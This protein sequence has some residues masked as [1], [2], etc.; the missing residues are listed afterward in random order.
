MA[1]PPPIIDAATLQKKHE[2]EGAPD[3]FPSLDSAPS[4]APAA[5][6]NGRP[7]TTSVEAFPCLAPSA[8]TN[9]VKSVWGSPVAPRIKA[10]ASKQPLYSDSFT[11]SVVDLSTAG[12]DGKPTSL[13]EIMR[14]VVAHHKIKLEASTNQ[15]SRQTTFYL[16]SESLKELDKAKRELLA[17]LSPVVTLVVN[18]PA[19]L[20]PTI[21]GSKGAT[22]KLIRDQTGVKIDIPRKDT[23]QVTGQ[24][25]SASGIETPAI[26]G[27]EEEEEEPTIPITIIGPQSSALEA[28]ALINERIAAR[29]SRSTQH[30]RDIPSHVLSFI[31]PH[32]SR[33]QDAAEG[34]DVTLALNVGAREITVS[35]DREGVVRVVETIKSAVTYFTNEITSFKITLPKRQHR[36]LTGKGAEDILAKSKCAVVIANIEEPGDEITV[37]GKPAD[38]AAGM[39]AVMEKANSAYIHEFPL[40]GPIAVSRQLLTYMTYVGYADT[41]AAAHPGVSVY[42][43]TASTAEKASVLNV[44]LVGDKPA[45]DNAVSQ[46][47]QL[48]GK[49]IGATKDVPI[50]WLIHRVI[51]SN[52]NAKK[53][54]AF[55]DVQNV[56]V[57]FPPESAEQSNVLLVYDPTSPN[58]SPSPVEKAG[59]LEEVEQE[60]LKLVKDAADVKTVTIPV[61]KKW[62]EAVV[63]KNGTTLNAIIGEDKALSIKLGADAGDASTEDIILIRGTSAD[64]NRASKEIQKI[65]EDAKNDEIVSSHVVEFVID[66][67]YVGRIV[68]ARGSGV[69]KLRD[70]L[71]VS[72]DFQ[73]EAEDKDEKTSKKKK[74]VQLVKVKIV[75]RKENTEDAEKR[76]KGQADRLADETSEI[77]KIPHEYHSS[78]IGQGGKYVIRLEENYAVKITFPRDSAEN[79]EGR[80]RETLKSDEV[81]IKGGKKGVADA[82]SELL[83]AVE[84]EKESNNVVKFSV[85]TRS[86]A[87]ILGKS[88]ATINEIKDDTGAQIDIDKVSDDQT[89]IQVRGTKTAIAEAKAAILAISDQVVEET[90]VLISVES[91][92]HRT[93]IGAGGQ[94]LKDLI[95]RCG[96]PSDPKI[97][98]G[99]VRFPRQ[100]EL[101]DDVRLRGEPKLVAK[102]QAELEKTVAQLKD[103]IVL[104]VDVPASQH[105][106][107][108]GRG[109][110]H[111]ND[112]QAK[113]GAQIQFPGSRS[114]NGVGEAENMEALGEVEPANLVKVSG[115]REACEK[116]VE[117]LKSLI[118]PPL[119]I[120]KMT[121]P[122]KYHHAVAQQGNFFRSLHTYGVQVEQSKQAQGPAVPVRPPAT[123]DT[124]GASARI[125]DADEEAPAV[126]VQWQVVSNYQDAEEGESVWTFKARDQAGLDKA[127]KLAEDAIAHAEKMSH[128][129]FL[130]LPDRSLFPRIV[131]TKGANVAKLRAESGADITVSRED[132]TIVI[133][134]SEEAIH[135]AKDAIL[136]TTTAQRPSRGGPRDGPRDGPRGGPRRD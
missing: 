75:G 111:L 116:A 35:G 97:Q 94:G 54:K 100:G 38:L 65:V 44:D 135:V 80:T 22:L 30:V 124:N 79:G 126:E 130:T 77:V 40:P 64:V 132:N 57:F 122:L 1:T 56:L 52:K 82:K 43:P 4:A 39:T 107:L 25:G 133:V 61:E 118:K 112:L 89:N 104:A 51:N 29:R 70:T 92:F 95:L 123:E 2:L 105:R 117:A 63:G 19:S 134:G 68:G 81:L 67:E 33:F 47:S 88:G 13:G 41:L 53:I 7:D 58:A 6:S 78:L 37:W 15:K 48:I 76:I 45:V 20:I 114:Y 34:A 136:K 102:L 83:E 125:D 98:A 127:L 106:S 109:G 9:A 93:L 16:K 120:A 115:T 27:E 101:S 66:R 49:L 74:P 69:N 23:L 55:H 131:G 18:A 36:L 46:V 119:T 90:T 91:R 21:I 113:T 85:P 26:T 12:K 86:V 71:G 103:R 11:L 87:R 110:Q 8:P 128:V 84:F 99:L 5:S 3:P 42:T 62:H 17:A 73:D 121:V 10:T 129:G 60:L 14:Q 24:N 31:V 32:R 50:D 59:K 28:Q 108:I 72:I 96:G